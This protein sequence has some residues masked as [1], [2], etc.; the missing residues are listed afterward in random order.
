MASDWAGEQDFWHTR[1]GSAVKGAG[2]GAAIGGPLG[3]APGALIGAGVGAATHKD[4]P[5][6]KPGQSY[7][8]WIA[9]VAEIDP[10]YAQSI[11]YK[12]RQD[13]A[14]FEQWKASKGF[15]VDK[16]AAA[17]ADREK[18]VRAGLDQF[19]QEMMRPLSAEDL[20]R[21]EVRMQLQQAQS[22]SDRHARLSGFGGSGMSGANSEQAYMYARAQ[23]EQ[24]R[25]DMG[26]RA[27]GMQLQDMSQVSDLRERARQFDV[28]QKM[29]ADQRKRQQEQA[30]YE[31]VGGGLGMV[32]GGLLGTF[33]APGIGTAAGAA[34]GARAGAGLGG[35]AY[36]TFGSQPAPYTPSGG[37]SGYGGSDYSRGGY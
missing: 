18:Q 11:Q 19:A 35:L 34:M 1:W 9:Q 26:L 25:K 28:G 12:S 37:M 21:P 24:Q 3:F 13:P 2:A 17:K 7:E 15:Y 27:T 30:M 22:A 20:N 36:G 23:M 32:A 14:G 33:A 16:E 5:Q 29:Q 31:G 4:I 8:E 6:P 10:E